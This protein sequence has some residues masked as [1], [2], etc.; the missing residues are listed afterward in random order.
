MR[1]AALV[2]G[3]N[4]VFGSAG[5][6]RCIANAPDVARQQFEI[7]MQQIDASRLIHDDLIEFLHGPLQVCEEG[8]EMNQSF[9]GSHG[10]LEWVEIA[11]ACFLNK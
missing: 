4:L 8:F 9:F 11:L 10:S 5:F 2:V 6:S 7:A 1:D 3:R